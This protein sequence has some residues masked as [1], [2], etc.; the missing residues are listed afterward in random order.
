[1]IA[2]LPP[3]TPGKTA[4]WKD[5]VD[6]L[7]WNPG[8]TKNEQTFHAALRAASLGVAR[9]AA[10]SLIADKIINSG[11]DYQEDKVD[12]QIDRAYEHVRGE[13]DGVPRPPRPKY[14]FQ[15]DKLA[16]VAAKIPDLDERWLGVRSPARVVSTSTYHF[17]RR[18]F[19]P[20]EAVIVF[21]QFESQG[22]VVWRHVGPE[23]DKNPANKLPTG[24]PDGVWFLIQPVD[25]H[26]HP[27]PRERG[28]PSRRSQE[29]VTAWRY[30]LLECDYEKN[31]PG[32]NALWLAA[33]VQMP[34]PIV[35]IYTSGGRSIHALIRV[36]AGSKQE[37]DEIRDKL[38]PIVIP[39]GADR[40]AMSAVRLSR[41]PKCTRGPEMQRLLFLNPDA[42]GT[43]I[44]EMRVCRTE[45]TFEEYSDE[46]DRRH[47]RGG[48]RS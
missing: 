34:L 25:G 40:Q 45:P 31:L 24:G 36:N 7:D 10:H 9:E 15:P 41:L 12:R 23:P 30:L 19:L 29:S 32:V 39:L 38:L 4:T 26:Y 33:L 20:G 16:V 21:D 44:A 6:S 27:N 1:V 28:K 3:G 43:P 17:L 18:L 2:T 22:Q 35:A 37:W 11:G 13:A 47:R 8:N 14:E 5:Y 42:D 48:R 46:I